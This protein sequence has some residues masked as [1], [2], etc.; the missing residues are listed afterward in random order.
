M[1]FVSSAKAGV[2]VASLDLTF[3]GSKPLNLKP[4]PFSSS[5]SLVR[6]IFKPTLNGC[7][8]ILL[9]TIIFKSFGMCN[10]WAD[11]KCEFVCRSFVATQEVVEKKSRGKPKSQLTLPTFSRVRFWFQDP[12]S[13]C[14]KIIIEQAWPISFCLVFTRRRPFL[15]HIHGRPSTCIY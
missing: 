8:W 9:V 14:F 4:T 10:L 6:V 11:T 5:S 7:I 3:S 13:T 15:G 2:I 1:V 12:L